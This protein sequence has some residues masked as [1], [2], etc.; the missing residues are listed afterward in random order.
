M[1]AVRER[2][3]E[4]D[5]GRRTTPPPP[6]SSRD[7]VMVGGMDDIEPLR[8]ELEEDKEKAPVRRPAGADPAPN[9]EESSDED[10]ERDARLAYDDDGT[11]GDAGTEERSSRRQRRNRSRREALASRDAE[12]A[13]LRNQLGQLSGAV[14]S[15]MQGQVGLSVHTIDNQLSAAQQA[16][17]MADEE[18]GRSVDAGDGKRFRE[19]QA[20]RDEAARRVYVLATTRQ[21]L[22][23]ES[24]GG[25]SAPQRTAPAPNPRAM[26][27]SEI[28]MERH[29]WFDPQGSDENSAIVKAIDDVLAAEGYN[30]A[31]PMYWRELE[32]RVRTRGLGPLTDSESSDDEGLA[33][34]PRRAVLP[35]TSSGR[36]SR[37]PG[38]PTFTL[39]P[40][41]RE[42]LDSEGLL[43]TK[44]DPEQKAK[45]DRLIFNWRANEQKAKQG[46]YNKS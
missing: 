42:Y 23:A 22:I 12:I 14:G 9:R 37:A 11:D 38:K 29:D 46:G 32:S 17:Q 36:G 35:P 16:Q 25:Q 1:A 30:P 6:P 34:T 15:L 41:M 43:E 13:G 10:V 27:L 3:I 19:V 7:T 26:Q 21:R 33:P 44:L 31:T 2:E 20:L 24:S 4:E 18:L 39:Q 8:I 45:R 28:F 40:E 5:R